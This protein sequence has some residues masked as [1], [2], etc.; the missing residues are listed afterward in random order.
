M[1]TFLAACM[2]YLCLSS[3]AHA[4]D[5]TPTLQAH[6][7]W[8]KAPPYNKSRSLEVIITTLKDGGV[9]TYYAGNLTKFT[10][11]SCATTGTLMSCAGDRVATHSDYPA[12]VYGNWSCVTDS[13][14]GG[15]FASCLN[16]FNEGPDRARVTLSTPY[17]LAKGGLSIVAQTGGV[18]SATI[19]LS[20]LSCDKGI[21]YGFTSALNSPLY[22]VEIKR[23]EVGIPQ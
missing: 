7:D 15:G 10:A 16:P 17:V 13:C 22:A 12:Y 9:A 8:V 19:P 23:L 6:L 5:C 11:K 2:A 21:M 14:G 18:S 3:A 20:S 1:K 4:A